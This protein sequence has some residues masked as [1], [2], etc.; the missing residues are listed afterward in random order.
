MDA[1][2]LSAEAA[3]LARAAAQLKLGDAEVM[4]ALAKTAERIVTPLLKAETPVKSG[5]LR[6][7]TAS[8]VTMVAGG[9]EIVWKSDAPYTRFVIEGTKPH[10]ITANGSALRFE[11]NGQVVYATSVNHPGT[12][13]NPFPKRAMTRAL[14]A[15]EAAAR[16][17][18][19]EILLRFR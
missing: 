17:M 3:R 12:K 18:G 5:R 2:G 9:A 19:R 16:L 8:T 10:T 7:S 14:P 1:P 13:P 15:I 6:K 4:A 11:V